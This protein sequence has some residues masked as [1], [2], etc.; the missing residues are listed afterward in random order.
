MEIN[1]LA[2]IGQ[3]LATAVF[4]GLSI[5]LIGRWKNRPKAPVIA[6]A[7]GA[8]AFW[9]SVQTV[10]SLA[11]V[12]SPLILLVVEWGRNLAW[13]V[14]LILIMRD[15]DVTRRAGTIATRYGA[16]FFLAAV[17][18]TAY[19]SIRTAQS[20]S[21][22]GVVVG[23]VMLPILILILVEQVYRNAPFDARSGLKYFCV[24]VA[25]IYLYDLVIFTFTIVNR[26][27]DVNQWAA[28]GF[29]NALFAVPLAFSARRSFRLSLDDYLP[30][31]ILF[32]AFSLVGIG[33]FVLFILIG[34]AYINAY[35]GTWA[36][37]LQIVFV[38]TALFF[39]AVVLV[40]PTVRAGVLVFLTK[41]FFQYKYDYRKEWLRFITTLNDSGSIDVATTS[42]KAVAQIVNSPG[43][44][45][46]VR[47]EHGRNFICAGEWQSDLPITPYIHESSSVLSFL[48]Q[49]QWIIDIKEY[50]NRPEKYDGLALDQWLDDKK[51]WWL[52]IPLYLRDELF[53]LIMLEAPPVVPTLNF[54]DRD[55]MHTVAKHVATYIDQAE[56]DRRLSESK[57]F[58]AYNRLTAF[59]MHDLNN[60]VAQQSL[61][62]KNAE[63][64][65]HNPD[66]VDDAINTIA[67]SVQRMRRLMAQLTDGTAQASTEDID[68]NEVLKKAVSRCN[69]MLPKPQIS[70]IGDGFIHANFERLTSVIEHLI[71][72]A[73]DATD[74]EGNIEISVFSNTKVLTIEICDTGFGMT[75]EFIRDRLFR[76]FD[77]T[78]GTQSMGIGAYQARE[79]IRQLAGQ[80]DVNSTPGSGTSF[81]IT[82]P[83]V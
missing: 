54:E 71:R 11:I 16:V 30:R 83:L 69:E 8:T 51:D 73:Q 66:F 49:R 19:Y 44:V 40:S 70:G 36:S 76:P 12:Q 35:G 31:Q 81:K 20:I 63:K 37:V 74:D 2:A 42:I 48:Q 46:W 27:M 32:Y 82:L 56:T 45:V 7:A 75:A 60:L 13:L 33:I 53:G 67:N 64:H 79:Y 21:M 68:L 39:I 22:I 17:L 15:L 52:V 78:K 29:V 43:G 61:V 59:L 23:G 28:R 5:L 18:L 4:A 26:E 14:V 47:E 55:L 25:G 72:N 6:M 1:E 77:S 34:D 50:V 80:L 41:T 24:G 3:G 57:Q 9:A 58:G 10:G 62:V 38:V 65:R